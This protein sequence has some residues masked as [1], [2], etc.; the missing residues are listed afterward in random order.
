MSRMVSLLV[1][2]TLIIGAVG[3]YDGSY[4]RNRGN[5]PWWNDRNRDYPD[6]S[7]RDRR[8]P[9]DNN[10]NDDCRRNRGRIDEGRW[11]YAVD[12]FSGRTFRK[13]KG[14][15]SAKEDLLNSLRDVRG[16]A[17]DWEQPAV[18][19]LIGRVRDMRFNEATGGVD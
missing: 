10:N 2:L 15:R 1:G 12:Q 17:C 11:R 3:C 5:D 8:P 13:L 16:R 6:D 19:R 18:D 9:Q 7:N 4:G 14:F